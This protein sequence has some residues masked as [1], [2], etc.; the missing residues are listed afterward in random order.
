MKPEIVSRIR[1]LESKD[2]TI[3]AA[4]VL[5]DAYDPTSPLHE[6]FE[7][8][9]SK[10]ASAHRLEQARGLIRSVRLV[11]TNEESTVRTVAYVRDP[12]KPTGEQGYISTFKLRQSPQ[13]ARAALMAELDR[14]DNAMDRATAVAN[15]LGLGG[16]IGEVRAALAGIKESA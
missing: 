2:G 12:A 6:C 15:S 3:T 11:I 13:D 7:W 16:Q 14:A 5:N 4:D 10:A 1:A 9:D 8:D